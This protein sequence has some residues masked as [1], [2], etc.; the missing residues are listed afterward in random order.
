M[1]ITM[2]TSRWRWITR[3]LFGL[4]VEKVSD[5]PG[6]Q[7]GLIRHSKFCPND[8]PGKLDRSGKFR[9][10]C[11]GFK[12]A[13]AAFEHMTPGSWGHSGNASDDPYYGQHR[14]DGPLD[15]LYLETTH[16]GMVVATGERNGYHDS[17][18]T[19]TVW[20]PE[21]G[22]LETIVYATTR[23]WSYPNH[24]EVDA[25]PEVL[26]A[27]NEAALKGRIKYLQDRAR[28]EAKHP[29]VGRKVRVVSKRSKV[30]HGTI[31]MVVWF[32]LSKYARS[33]GTTMTGALILKDHRVGIKTTSGETVW[34]GA[35][36]VEVVD[37]EPV[38]EKAI[39]ERA[40]AMGPAYAV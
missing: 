30:P 8:E 34:C 14:C 6:H 32:G 5:Y 27:V 26:A 7:E 31:G 25:T 12:R 37:V 16:E 2:M 22:K 17:D 18:F 9:P 11:R 1:A 38:D 33:R 21:E 3:N 23:G 19:A 35:A 13:G 24:A 28:E 36:C 15:A 39:E 10:G 40:R 4:K 29:V 20:L